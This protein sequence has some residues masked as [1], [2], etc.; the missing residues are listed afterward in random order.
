MSKHN[1]SHWDRFIAQHIADAER[2]QFEEEGYVD[3]DDDYVRAFNAG[4]DYQPEES[5]N[6]D[7]DSDEEDDC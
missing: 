6:E 3:E 7:E 1:M 4:W 2:E 5:D